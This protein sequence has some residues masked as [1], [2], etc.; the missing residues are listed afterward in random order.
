MNKKLSFGKI[1]GIIF[2]ITAAAGTVLLLLANAYFSGQMK[3]I[4][5]YYTALERDDYDSFLSCFGHEQV[6]LNI[7]G[8]N[9]SFDDE[10]AAISILKDSENVHAKTEFISRDKI[11]KN[12]YMVYYDLTIYNNDESAENSKLCLSLAREHGEW[13]IE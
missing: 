4:D 1:L 6:H 8:I 11:G 7:I 10:K 13:V 3:L 5:K 12:R 2:C 9:K